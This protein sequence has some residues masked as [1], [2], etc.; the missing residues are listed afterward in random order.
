MNVRPEI[1][2]LAAYA[3]QKETHAVKAKLDFNE[4]PHDVPEVIMH[5]KLYE[6][7]PAGAPAWP[8]PI[9]PSWSRRW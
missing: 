2:A 5:R 3:L 9:I 6:Y 4:S 8:H 7:V 1:R